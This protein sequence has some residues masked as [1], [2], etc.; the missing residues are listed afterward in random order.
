MYRKAANV[1]LPILALAASFGPG[2]AIAETLNNSGSSGHC[3]TIAPGPVAIYDLDNIL[4]SVVSQD[5]VAVDAIRNTLAQYPFAID[6]KNYDRLDKVF[7]QNAVVNYSAPIGVLSG[8]PAIKTI[9]D[10]LAMFNRTHHSYG[11][12]YIKICSPSSAIA[13]TYYTASHFL[14]PDLGPTFA[15]DTQALYAYGQYQDTLAKQNDGT[16]KVTYRNLVYQGP[17][18]IDQNS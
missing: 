4:P 6:G 9:A 1:L 18:I 12:Q 15:P 13:I 5:V 14:T 3:P 16:W 10:G 8:L 11:T 17:L 2:L 7:T